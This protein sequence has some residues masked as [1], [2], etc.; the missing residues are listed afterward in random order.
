MINPLLSLLR[1]G[2][3][4]VVP[5]GKDF[6]RLPFG[7]AA[8]CVMKVD[9]HHGFQM[10]LGIYERELWRHFKRLV[11]PGYNS[12]DVGGQGGYYALL[13]AK[14]SSG[15]VVSF[16]CDKGAADEMRDTF[17]R[18][19]YR[20]ATIEA[21]VGD[22]VADPG[23]TTL[24]AVAAQ[25]FV[26]DFIKMDIEGAEHQALL[27]ASA[28]LSGRKPSLIIEVHGRDI[29]D[30]CRKI[31]VSYGYTPEVVDQRQFL[32]EVRPLAHN[33]W[34]VCPGRTN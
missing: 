3:N 23:T 18:N 26:P 25:T 29:E 10:Y 30:E 15:Q 21:F 27:G 12:F 14:M 17:A 4:A 33:R 5:K 31:L 24:D 22:T 16:E 13:L 8:G 20:I 34:L 19:S 1:A 11:R 2:K 6:R 7:P 9:F 32:K 28:I